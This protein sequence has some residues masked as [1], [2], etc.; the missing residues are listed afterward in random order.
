MLT[1]R[2]QDQGPTDPHR[3]EESAVPGALPI[4]NI[5]VG[6]DFPIPDAK[7][8]EFRLEGGF[9]DAFFIG[10]SGGYAF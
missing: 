6:L 1:E 2:A 5:L 4:L 9:Y 8:L 3:F 7:G 10:L